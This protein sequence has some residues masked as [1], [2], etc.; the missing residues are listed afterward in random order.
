MR[1]GAGSPQSLA[2]AR[3]S[4]RSRARAVAE[5]GVVSG[6]TSSAAATAADLDASADETA[7]RTDDGT[8]IAVEGLAGPDGVTAADARWPTA[9][10]QAA[11]HEDWRRPRGSQP[12][13]R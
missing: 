13:R 9:R 2:R 7:A 5:I 1:S 10:L 12:R 6:A 8:T 3:A 11:R 4:V